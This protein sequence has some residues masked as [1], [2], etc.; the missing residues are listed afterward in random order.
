MTIQEFVS[1]LLPSILSVA[2]AL[3]SLIVCLIRT[4]HSRLHG[5]SDVHLSD[6]SVVVGS[7]EIPL[8]KVQLKKRK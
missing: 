2:T 4:R 3:C 7:Q 8:D 5:S 1:Q 6:Y